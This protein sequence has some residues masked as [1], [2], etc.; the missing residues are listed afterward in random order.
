MNNAR[1]DVRRLRL[2]LELRGSGRWPRWP[3]S[4]A[5]RPRTSPRASPPWPDV[6]TPLDR[7][8]RTPGPPHSGRAP[9][10]RARRHHPRRGR[11]RP[12]RPRPGGG[13]GRGG[14]GGGVRDRDPPIAAAGR[15]RRPGARPSRPRGP[16]PRARASRGDR[17]ARPRRHR[18]RADLRLQPRAGVVAQRARR[19]P[20]LGGRVG[21]RPARAWPTATDLRRTP[22]TTGS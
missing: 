22:T 17:P 11:R 15:G 20:A 12:A 7:A 8:R 2:L 18:P 21:P 16:H 19:H 14:A 10:R 9:P 6:G 1:M 4:S 13:A 3:P 5:P